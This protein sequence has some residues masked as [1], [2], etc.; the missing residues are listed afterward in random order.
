M[1]S[2]QTEKKVP[3]PTRA[4][5]REICF[6]YSTYAKETLGREVANMS[7]T[8][9]KQ[10]KERERSKELANRPRPAHLCPPRFGPCRL[11]APACDLTARSKRKRSGGTTYRHN[12]AGERAFN[13]SRWARSGGRFKELGSTILRRDKW[14]YRRD[15]GDSDTPSLLLAADTRRH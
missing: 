14:G 12:A 6:R 15:A 5:Q 9:R 2:L 1:L 13:K 10:K 7:A 8:K 4:Q 3:L 11:R